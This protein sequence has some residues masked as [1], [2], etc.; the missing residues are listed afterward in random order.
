ME[1]VLALEDAESRTLLAAAVL[2]GRRGGIWRLT[3]TVEL[4]IMQATT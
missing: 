2:A 1:R 3:H 4:G